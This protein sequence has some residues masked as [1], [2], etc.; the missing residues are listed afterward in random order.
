MFQVV[1]KEANDMMDLFRLQKFDGKIKVQGNLMLHGPLLCTECPSNA[2]RNS[3]L[4]IKPR[5]MQVFLF[6]Q[7][8]IFSEIVGKKTQFVNPSYIYKNHIQ[9]RL[10]CT[11]QVCHYVE[12]IHDIHNGPIF[13]LSICSSIKWQNS[14]T[15]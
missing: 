8:I 13:P 2:D 10:F 12:N 3:S 6:Q 9:V 14:M 15:N 5:E 7:S 11:K 4:A 1:P